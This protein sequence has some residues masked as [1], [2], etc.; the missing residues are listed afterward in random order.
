VNSTT[1]AKA[2]L[3]APANF[4]AVVE[5]LAA[6]RRDVAA[7]MGQ[8]KSGA[9]KGASDTAEGALGQL[10]DRA[11]HLYDSLAAQGERSAKAIG[12]QIEE[13]PVMS[14]LIAFGVGF[15]AGKL[16]IR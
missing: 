5:D 7:L 6:L 15:I 10:N 16:L 8:I 9:F 11:N 4:D 12:R 14:L 1:K 13:Q 2:D 3:E